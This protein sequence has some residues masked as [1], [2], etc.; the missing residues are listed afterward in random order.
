MTAARTGASGQPLSALDH[1]EEL[2]DDPHAAL[3]IEG[4]EL[5]HVPSKTKIQFRGQ[6]VDCRAPPVSR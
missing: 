6:M 5:Q 3:I 1:F 4:N 2:E